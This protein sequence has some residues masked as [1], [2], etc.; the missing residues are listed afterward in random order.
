[1]GVGVR[2]D[3]RGQ[4]LHRPGQKFRTGRR[5]RKMH[6]EGGR[7]TKLHKRDRKSTHLLKLPVH[8]ALMGAYK[9]LLGPERGGTAAEGL[10]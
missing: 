5:A 8:P 1:M 9:G 10:R 4:G 7:K 2:Q 6:G 3:H